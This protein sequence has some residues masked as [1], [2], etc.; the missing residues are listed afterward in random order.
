MVDCVYLNIAVIVCLFEI[1]HQ[2]T[3]H[4]CGVPDTMHVVKY[5]KLARLA[6]LCTLNH[7]GCASC[8][9]HVKFMR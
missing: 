4:C 6:R 1:I 2:F 9:L 7:A 8:A 3:L 5:V